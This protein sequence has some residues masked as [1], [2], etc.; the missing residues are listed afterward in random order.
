MA[1]LFPAWS[2]RRSRRNLVGS[3]KEACEEEE[4][5]SLERW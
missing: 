1:G 5:K 4:E 3:Q 2:A